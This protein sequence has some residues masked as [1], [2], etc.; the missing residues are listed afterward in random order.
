MRN[1]IVKEKQS[2]NLGEQGGTWK[3]WGR[4]GKVESDVIV[5]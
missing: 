3:Y 2:T 5:F 1:K 4:N